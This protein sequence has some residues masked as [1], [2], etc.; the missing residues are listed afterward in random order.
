MKKQ[1]D[2]YHIQNRIGDGAFAKVY[3][4]TDDASHQFAVKQYSINFLLSL[5]LVD[6]QTMQFKDGMCMFEKETKVI[7]LLTQEPSYV[8]HF[9]KYYQIIETPEYIN[10]VMELSRFGPLTSFDDET[11]TYSLSTQIKDQ[12]AFSFELRAKQW[13]GQMVESVEYLHSRNIA[14][15]D[16][17]LENFLLFGESIDSAKLKLIDFNSALVVEDP[18]YLHG[19]KYGTIL[20]GSPESYTDLLEGYDPFKADI[21]ALGVSMYILLAMRLPFFDE[22]LVKKNTNCEGVCYGNANSNFEMKYSMLVQ[23]QEVSLEGFSK[24]FGEL[25][26]GMLEKD[27]KERWDISK[28][29]KSQFV[30]E[31]LGGDDE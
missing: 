10:L 22:S 18:A 19:D 14:H 31:I 1:F 11:L 5:R 13:I 29:M 3:L 24:E 21:W 16:I 15:M 6:H 9:P 20:Y 4:A 23:K 8:Q 28:V 30:Q 17:K 26:Q 12:M 27:P 2:K 7:G 25:I